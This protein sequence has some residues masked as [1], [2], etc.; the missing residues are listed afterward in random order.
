MNKKRYQ[1][2][3]KRLNEKYNPCGWS[4]TN[5]SWTVYDNILLRQLNCFKLTQYPHSMAVLI[6]ELNLSE[7]QQHP[8]FYENKI[9][10]LKQKY[11]CALGDIIY[12]NFSDNDEITYELYA[13]NL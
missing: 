3:L 12:L 9:R 4:I 6:V 7:Q 2:T 11:N 8:D 5:P 10:E 1:A 13:D